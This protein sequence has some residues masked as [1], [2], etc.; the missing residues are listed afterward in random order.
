MTTTTK[1]TLSDLSDY[2]R[3]LRDT[4]KQLSGLD[5]ALKTLR[6]KAAAEG[7]TLEAWFA[8]ERRQRV[9]NDNRP[10]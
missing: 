6:K 4:K 5:A 3:D 1:P 10:H 9:A 8:E 7:M 2:D